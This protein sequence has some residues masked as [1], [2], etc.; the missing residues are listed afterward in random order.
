MSKRLIFSLFTNTSTIGPRAFAV[1]PS[2]WNCL[3]VDL[4]DPGH[5]LLTFRRKLGTHQFNLF[6]HR[7][8][9]F[10]LMTYFLTDQHAM[11]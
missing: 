10:I 9:Y 11:A 3:P 8:S 4:R 5:S 1:S 7:F 2:A 6:T